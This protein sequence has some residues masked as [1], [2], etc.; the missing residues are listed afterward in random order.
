MFVVIYCWRLKPG[1][2][3][4]FIRQWSLGTSRIREQC[5]SGGSALFRSDDGTYVA[6]AR[7]PDREARDRCVVDDNSHLAAMRDCLAEECFE[8]QRLTTVADLWAAL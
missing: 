7:W 6:V 2:E 5:G 1:R 3:D 8:E 4:E